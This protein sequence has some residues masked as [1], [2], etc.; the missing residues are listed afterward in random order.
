MR[1][2]WRLSTMPTTR[3]LGALAALLLLPCGAQAATV[4]REQV[5]RASDGIALHTSITGE[6]PLAARPTIVEFTPYAL[7][8]TRSFAG[9]A[10]NSLIVH[11]RGTGRSAG[12]WDVAGPR[13]QRDIAEVLAWACKQ[14]W[15]NGDL[16][17]YGASA[18]AIA[19]YTAMRDKALPC[20]RTAVLAAGTSSL[21]RDVGV[22]GGVQNAV[23]VAAF[24]GLVV[25]P[26][27]QN[28]PTRLQERP[29]TV[30]EGIA[31]YAAQAAGYFQHPT[32]DAFWKAR[33]FPGPDGP[34]A[35]PILAETGFYDLESRGPFEA[36]KSTRDRGSHL[37]VMG[38]H[39]GFA[40]GSPGPW[41]EFRRWFDHHLRGVDNGIDREPPV[42]LYAGNGGYLDFAAGRWTKVQAGDWPVPGTRWDALRLDPARSG[43]ARSINDGTLTTGRVRATSQAY[44]LVPSNPLATDPYTTPLVTSA[45]AGAAQLPIAIPSLGDLRTAEATS[46]TYTSAPLSSP[47]LS[48]GPAAL[49]V[50][51]ASTMT[52]SDLFA[53]IADVHPDGSAHAVATGRLRT[54]FPHIDLARSIVDGNG[55]VVQPF[56]RHDFKARALPGQTRE[57]HLEFWPIGNRFA[58]GHRIRLYIGGAPATMLGSV[59]ALNTVRL[60]SAR[61]LLPVVPT[62]AP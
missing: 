30:T 33:E 5:V 46:L 32:E 3:L 9:A 36:Y 61:L 48:T 13:E 60:G 40:G 45:V 53:V 29:E 27:L 54:S 59:P 47:L 2:D 52:E 4:A 57:Y 17:L 43:S 21:Y 7:G 37:L 19:A 23:P 35:F 26:W 24:F 14:P 1:A 62:S 22:I 41:G 44:P 16:A 12:G 51:M 8:P 39:E 18:S 15:S 49:T 34:P 28:L 6:A 56:S 20:V 11:A 50:Q 58:P 38:T 31:G 55:E 10:Y 42:T 25:A